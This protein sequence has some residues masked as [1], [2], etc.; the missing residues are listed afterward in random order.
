MATVDTSS[1]S[2]STSAIHT[3]KFNVP[4]SGNVHNGLLNFVKHLKIF[5][6]LAEVAKSKGLGENPVCH[7]V[8][9]HH[10]EVQNVISFLQEPLKHA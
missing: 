8:L 6:G 4:L 1:S 3:E 5:T 9:C 10:N 7:I 2:A